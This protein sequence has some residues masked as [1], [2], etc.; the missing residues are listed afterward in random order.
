MTAARTAIKNQRGGFAVAPQLTPALHYRYRQY[1][2][3][4]PEIGVAPFRLINIDSDAVLGIYYETDTR[5]ILTFV[6]FSD[7]PVNFTARGIRH[8]TGPPAADKRYNDALV[9]GKTVALNLSGYGYRWFW[10]DR[11][12]LR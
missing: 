5:S 10:T 7:K 3:G 12:A 9:G 1:A 6:N 11:T 2:L 4:F 8:A